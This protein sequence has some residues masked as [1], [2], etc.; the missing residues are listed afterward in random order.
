M[1]AHARA[2]L[3]STPEGATQYVDASLN[4]ADTIVRE[5]AK[6]LDF[7]RP[8]ALMLL[9]I[10]GHVEKHDEARAIVAALVDRLPSGSYLAMSDG[11]STSAAVVESHR[12]Y[13][14]SG[15]VPYHLR[16]PGEI[17]EFFNGLDLVEPGVVPFTQWR[18]EEAPAYVDG[19]CG[20]GR[21]P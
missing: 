11:T 18:P 16:S 7:E 6:T 20:V 15:A 9:G 1:L 14:E 19:Y 13:N 10:M 21:K 5:A 4:D 3:T 17:E 8:V 2:L 12:Q